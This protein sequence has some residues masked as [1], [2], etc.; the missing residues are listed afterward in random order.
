MGIFIKILSTLLVV[1]MCRIFIIDVVAN[2][3]N[4]EYGYALIGMILLVYFAYSE[5]KLLTNF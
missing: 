4:K 5:Y 3:K 1:I 2:I